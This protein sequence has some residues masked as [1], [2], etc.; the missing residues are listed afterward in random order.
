VP[1]QRFLEGAVFDQEIITAMS[2]AFEET[3]KELGLTDRQDPLIAV[4]AKIIID[5]ARKGDREPASMRDCA[6]AA[7]RDPPSH[8]A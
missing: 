2:I 4:V 8:A 1:I 5:C 7:I 3:L 6:L